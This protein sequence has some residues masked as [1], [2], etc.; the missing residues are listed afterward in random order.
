MYKDN[1]K[2]DVNDANHEVMGREQWQALVNTVIKFGYY[3]LND[4]VSQYLLNG[5]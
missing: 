1:I 3:L 4:S 5:P 2:M